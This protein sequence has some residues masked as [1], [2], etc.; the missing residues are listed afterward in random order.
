MYF[1]A[2]YVS[3]FGFQLPVTIPSAPDLHPFRT[4]LNLH[5]IS[6]VWSKGDLKV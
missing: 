3:N 1:P 5:P 4:S 2:S 6:T